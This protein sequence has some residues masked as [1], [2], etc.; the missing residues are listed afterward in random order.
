MI[1]RPHIAHGLLYIDHSQEILPDQK[2]LTR[3]STVQLLA[4]IFASQRMG[5]ELLLRYLGGM[6]T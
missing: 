3:A 4:H 5:A 2:S 6:L 1:L